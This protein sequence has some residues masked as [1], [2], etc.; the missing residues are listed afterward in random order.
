MAKVLKHNPM[1][2][3][4]N[5]YDF[6]G[7]SAEMKLPPCSEVIFQDME[8]KYYGQG[9]SWE[10]QPQKSIEDR[11]LKVINA[12]LRSR[13]PDAGSH[14]GYTVEIYVQEYMP[15]RL[16]LILNRMKDLVDAKV[17]FYLPDRDY[18]WHRLPYGQ[19]LPK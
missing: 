1:V 12:E 5:A 16:R 18:N 19:I 14:F 7:N 13:D 15:R 9:W 4:L 8:M 2:V 3:R 10:T 6:S 17:E 11:I